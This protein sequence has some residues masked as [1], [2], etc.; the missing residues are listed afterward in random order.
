M[1]KCRLVGGLFDGKEVFCAT[2]PMS[3]RMP[4]PVHG[5]AA[6][7]PTPPSSEPPIILEYRRI[8]ED[9]KCYAADGAL[10]LTVDDIW[11]HMQT[12][13]EPHD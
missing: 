12:A 2:P 7:K 4:V 6:A 3:L 11:H 1:I 13:K 8:T 9:D 10:L 5:S